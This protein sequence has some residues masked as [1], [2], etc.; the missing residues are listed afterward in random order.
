MR[1]ASIYLI[2]LVCLMALVAGVALAAGP[3]WAGL[4]ALF[5]VPAWLAV[6]GLHLFGAS[7]AGMVEK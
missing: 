7:L 1:A 4:L 2:A 3:V 5:G 6:G